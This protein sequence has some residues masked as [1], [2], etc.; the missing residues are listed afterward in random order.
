MPA[1]PRAARRLPAALA[2]AAALAA[3]AGAAPAAPP[4]VVAD[5]PV[6]HALAAQV[7]AGVGE[8]VL[9]I[10]RGAD[11]H[12]FQLRPSQARALAAADVVFWVGPELAPWMA[13]ALEGTGAAGAAVA[14]LRAEGVRLRSYAD[15]AAAE[16]HAHGA[17]QDHGHGH[18]H[19][20]HA[21]DGQAAGD[22]AHDGHAQDGHDHGGHDHGAHAGAGHAAQGHDHG[23]H[24]HEGHDHG[25]PGAPHVHTGTDPHAWLDPHNV[26]VWIGAIAAELARR[27]PENAAAYAANAARALAEV[28]AV[29]A[30]VAR[31]IAPAAAT[32]L[33]MF[34]DAYG[35]LAARYGL[36][37]AGSLALGDASA[38][39]AARLSA[40]RAR[41][42]ALEGACIFPE[43][44]HDAR[45][46]RAVAEG[47]GARIGAALD[48]SGT[49][50]PPG[51][52]LWAALMR[53]LAT[54][55]ADCAAGR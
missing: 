8:P 39:G 24:G 17:A 45:L 28:Q 42:A 25:G 9:L 35:Y 33:V 16:A 19:D 13:R 38:P 27:D 26:E 32:P 22:H 15:P 3:T 23:G 12:S 2:L 1:H 49:T 52:G 40:L 43:A 21:Q 34:H 44:Q 14:L 6:V 20:G 10:D 37:Y 55:I 31:L 46:V 11:P 18:A 53:G 50:L 5:T 4:A 41:L 47:T 7:M 36:N 29:D 51:P 30:E 48:P 54:A